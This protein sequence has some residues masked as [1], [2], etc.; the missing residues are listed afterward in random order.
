MKKATINAIRLGILIMLLISDKLSG[1]LTTY[2]WP[3]GEGE[4]WISEYYKVYVTHGSEEEEEL[5]VLK[6]NAIYSGDYREDYLKGR[7]FSFAQVSY[8]EAI[9]EGLTFRVVKN[10][11][12]AAGSAVLAPRSYGLEHGL[13]GDG[14]EL[15]FQVDTS[16]RYIS[17]KFNATDNSV[18][19]DPNQ[20]WIKH[21]LCIFINPAEKDAPGETDPGIV[22]YNPDKPVAELEAADVLYFPAG[23]YNLEEYAYP[24]SYISDRGKLTLKKDQD[25]YMEGGAFVEGNIYTGGDHSRISGR[26]ILSM[27]QY[28]WKN[29]ADYDGYDAGYIIHLGKNCTVEGIMCMEPPWHGIVGGLDNLIENIK[30]LGWHSNN[31]GVRVGSGSEI[32]NSFMRT[33]DDD[34]Y[35]F[36]IHVHDMVLWKGHNGSIMTYG[37]G[38]E[39]TYNSGASLMEDV[40]VINPEWTGLGNNNGLIMS[41]TAYD[42]IPY[43][44]GTGS[45]TTTFRNIRIEGKIPGLVNVKTKEGGDTP[46]PKVP[47][48][49]VG[50]LGDLVLEN[51]TVNQQFDKGLIA[52]KT[53]VASDGD[54]DYFVQNISMEE[55]LIGGICVNNDNK[56]QFFHIDEAT[57]RKL[58]FKG[59]N[60]TGI[61]I[62]FVQPLDGDKV[63]V[64]DSLEVVANI[65][66]TDGSITGASLY[67]NEELVSEKKEAPYIW[68][69]D[70]L[71]V[72]MQ[73][74]EYML[75]IHATNDSG[76]SWEESVQFTVTPLPNMENLRILVRSDSSLLLQWDNEIK[77]ETGIIVERALAGTDSYLRLD[78]LAA[79]DTAYLDTDLDDF[80][81]YAYRIRTLYPEGATQATDPF[82][83]RPLI[84]EHAVLPEPWE[85]AV[86]G[87]TLVAMSSTSTYLNDTFTIDAGDGDFWTEN[88]RGHFVYQSLTGDCE[89]SALVTDYSHAQS[90]S[91]A[92]VMIRDSIGSG[93]AFATMFLISDPGAIVRI[94]Q[95]SNGPVNQEI[96]NTGEH[97]PYW[98][99]LRRMGDVF[100]GSVSQ[101]GVSWRIVRNGSIQMN[102][103]VFIGLAATTHSTDTVGD[104]C[105]THVT[106]G[107]PANEYTISASAS[108]G[109]SIAPSGSHLVLEGATLTFTFEANEGYEL[110]DFLV[111]DVSQGVS[112]SYIFSNIGSNH[113]IKAMFQRIVSIENEPAANLLRIYPNPVSGILHIELR[114]G[115]QSDSPYTLLNV[116]GKAVY[117]GKLHQ[118]KGNVDTSV[119]DPGIYLLQVQL[120]VQ[121][122]IRRIIIE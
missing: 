33:V 74:G 105:F 29:S 51:I 5:H 49:D 38:G 121:K 111:D 88:D 67:L 85:N 48:A 114:E 9:G 101:D 40:D 71:L 93:S 119:Y 103:T 44:Y 62:E 50:Y 122:L 56:L 17:V 37:W 24:G 46:L 106:L 97:A 112:E 30:F 115:D 10:F 32:R 3:I 116:I 53:D 64:G 19:V 77:N 36:N 79:N 60:E 35:N 92:G 91:M 113:S 100:T 52:G 84:T 72:D 117:S 43:D 96:N 104:Y 75:K 107:N 13:S 98:V 26:G 109:G 76:S 108:T 42:Y 54:A 1:Q 28:H 90:Y 8:D 34:F 83:G 55:V 7:T 63:V 87:D 70:S 27:R 69:G 118:G 25:L 6:S 4:A 21:M 14:K 120:G 23:Y 66:D 15:S 110:A 65:S 45:T 2:T 57:T 58:F 68:K 78:T 89:I 80:T 11:G 61:A 102:P 20:S 82:L 18:Y 47:M 95:E 73:I 16:N 41:Q 39:N 94:R 22:F 99:R 81:L 59:C 86:F 12:S 31:D